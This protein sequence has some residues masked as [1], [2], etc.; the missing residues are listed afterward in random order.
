M[1]SLPDRWTVRIVV[2]GLAT[3]LLACVLGVVVLVSI[4]RDPRDLLPLATGALGALGALL[5][6]T[7]TE[8]QTDP[9]PVSIVPQ[10][11]PLPVT[12]VP[13]T[14]VDGGGD[15]SGGVSL[16]PPARKTTTRGRK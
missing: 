16:R 4:G 3:A 8:P 6:K 12:P 14:P 9:T 11:D 5:S 10:S 1:G 7:S 15:E 13:P 2:I